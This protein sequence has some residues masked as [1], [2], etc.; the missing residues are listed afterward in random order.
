[1]SIIEAEDLARSGS[2]ECIGALD[3]LALY[4]IVLCRRLLYIIDNKSR[5][6][7][8]GIACAAAALRALGPESK[9]IC[10]TGGMITART[11]T[12]REATSMPST[13]VFSQNTNVLC[14]LSGTPLPDSAMPLS[15]PN[16]EG[17][18]S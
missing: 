14:L 9:Q 7:S 10:A 5:R 3:L 6:D 8:G 13:D 15:S 2:K 4:W 12:L 18:S 1:M 17:F 16:A 11:H